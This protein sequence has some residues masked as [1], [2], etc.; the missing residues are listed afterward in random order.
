MYHYKIMYNLVMQPNEAN[1]KEK[2]VKYKQ[3]MKGVEKGVEAPQRLTGKV[4]ILFLKWVWFMG[5]CCIVFLT[6]LYVLRKILLQ[7]LN[8]NVF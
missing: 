4:N 3:K 7:L 5:I 8:N 6:T 2:Q 1:W